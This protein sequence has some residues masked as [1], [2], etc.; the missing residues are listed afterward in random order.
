M[1]SM[2]ETPSAKLVSCTTELADHKAPLGG[3]RGGR[4]TLEALFASSLSI[5][6]ETVNNIKITMDDSNEK[7]LGCQEYF[8][9]YLG[10]EEYRGGVGLVLRPT[11]DGNF[12]RVG[13]LRVST[14]EKEIIWPERLQPQTFTIV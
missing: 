7:A 4:L 14:A 13:R 6:S 3:V 8:Y 5:N 12:V 9:I 1:L 11:T 10:T 2:I